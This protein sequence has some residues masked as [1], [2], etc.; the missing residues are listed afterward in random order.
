MRES[1]TSRIVIAV[2]TRNRAYDEVR[3][4]IVSPSGFFTGTDTTVA[5]HSK[6]SISTEERFLLAVRFLKLQK[7]NGGAS[8]RFH[9]ILRGKLLYTRQN[10]MP[11]NRD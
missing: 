1:A 2:I 4:C 9:R 11:G 8:A 3:Q 10:G 7:E 6:R 5:R